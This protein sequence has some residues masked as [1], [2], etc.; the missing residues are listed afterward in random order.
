MIRLLW[1]KAEVGVLGSM[2]EAH[3]HD[4]WAVAGLIR[5]DMAA[6]EGGHWSEVE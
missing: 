5:A 2:Y 4:G 1:A 3:D 6:L